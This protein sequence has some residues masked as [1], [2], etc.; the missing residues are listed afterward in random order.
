MGSGEA[1]GDDE[2]PIER[3]KAAGEGCVECPR[4]ILNNAQKEESVSHDCHEAIVC[5]IYKKG[6]KTIVD[7]TEVYPFY[8]ILG[9]FMR[10]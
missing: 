9:N 10:E 5:P 3:F 8:R 2:L 4:Y 7:I 1:A 6:S